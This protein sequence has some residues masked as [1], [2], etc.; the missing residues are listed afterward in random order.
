MPSRR[1]F[2]VQSAA[3]TVG[4]WGLSGQAATAAEPT[5]KGF[6]KAVKI[7]MVKTPG[8]LEDKFRVLK[9]LGFDGVELNAPGGPEP[10]V[11]K[12]AIDATGLPVHGVVDSVH[13]K[14]TLS[15]PNPDVRAKGLAA[16]KGALQASKDYGGTSV[17]LVPAKVREDANYEQ[18][19]TRSI[20]EIR[21]ALPL[22]EKLQIQI[23]LENVWNDF[24]TDPKETARYI[25]ELDSEM[26]GAYFDVGNTVRYSPP[27][28]WIPILGKRIKKLDIKEFAKPPGAGFGAPLMQ[29]DVDWPKVM[30]ELAKIEF[31]GWGTAEIRGGDRERLAEIASRMNQ[32][33]AS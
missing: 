19:W 24:L 5:P 18:C 33:F 11:V 13:W 10:D 4:A 6:K 1:Q 9:E 21:K 23:L 3:L 7:G 28:E 14:E 31:V 27:H 2:L 8:A 25:D 15:D 30:D 20:A 22:A 12:A 32:I 16:L 26:V 17:L 29:G